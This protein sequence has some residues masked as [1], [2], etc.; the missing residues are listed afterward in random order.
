[1]DEQEQM[2]FFYEIFDASLPRLGPGDDASTRKALDMLLTTRP[3][4]KDAKLRI[5]DI[6]CGNGAQTIQLAKYADGT[7]T[8]VDNHK[9]FLD[10][11]QRR[12][13]AESL[14]AKIEFCLKDMRALGIEMGSFDL[15]WAE[16][17]LFI[18][19]FREGLEA[20][21][22]L[23]TPSGLLAARKICHY[24]PN[25][26]KTENARRGSL[27]RSYLGG[28]VDSGRLHLSLHAPLRPVY[29]GLSYRSGMGGQ[30]G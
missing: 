28:V 22:D 1:M 20:C 17:S 23:L 15:I 19:G 9:P 7:I 18:M 14:S 2:Q 4:R 10:E 26:D 5:L 13:E 6:G 11:L 29:K 30:R 24:R 27:L 3:Q 25:T 21:H 8:A 16:G 12:A